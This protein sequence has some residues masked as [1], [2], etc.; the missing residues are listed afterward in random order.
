MSL[1]IV[2]LLVMTLLSSSVMTVM[3]FYQ[4]FPN[5]V[6]LTALL[7]Y[8][9]KGSVTVSVTHRTLRNYN[10][11][12]GFYNHNTNRI[13]LNGWNDA[14]KNEDCGAQQNAGL[15]N[16]PKIND[17]VTIN[18]KKCKVTTPIKQTCAKGYHNKTETPS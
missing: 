1:L 8:N 15:N 16:G 2:A 17:Q 9:R 18:G 6:P 7:Y 3:S 12:T 11:I 14:F 5:K 13:L 10:Y 4:S